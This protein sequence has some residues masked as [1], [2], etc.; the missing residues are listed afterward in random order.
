MKAKGIIYVPFLLPNTNHPLEESEK[1]RKGE[2][3]G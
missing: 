3:V 2:C 1:E